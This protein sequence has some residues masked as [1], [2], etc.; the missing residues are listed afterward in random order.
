MECH[1]EQVAYS[2]RF[3]SVTSSDYLLGEADHRLL[4]AAVARFWR[5]ERIPAGA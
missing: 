4:L 2:L 1:G 5:Q 3:L